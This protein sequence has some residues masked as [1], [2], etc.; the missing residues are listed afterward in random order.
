MKQE[1]SQIPNSHAG[2]V[3]EVFAVFLQLGLTSFG[4][5]IAQSGPNPEELWE[6][7]R[8]IQCPTL[9]V[10]GG[11]SDILSPQAAERLQAAIPN[12]QLSVVAGAGHSVMGDNPDGFAKAVQEFLKILD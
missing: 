12:S 6:D 5:P 4:G 9:I 10:R 8:K 3:V 11:E 7:V 2:S 1:A